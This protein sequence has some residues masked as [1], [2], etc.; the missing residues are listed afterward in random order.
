MSDAAQ[1]FKKPGSRRNATAVAEKGLADNSRD[2]RTALGEDP[3][4][5]I[6]IVPLRDECLL[7]RQLPARDGYGNA[8]RARD[9]L[10]RGVIAGEHPVAPAV[11]MSF[12]LQ[13][14]A[15]ARG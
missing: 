10:R 14:Q 2:F 6:A 4:N 7:G 1:S 11:V 3:L 12:E 9:L 5:A 13:D 8:V 15:A